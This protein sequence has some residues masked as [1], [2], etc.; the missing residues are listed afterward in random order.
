MTNL[1]AALPANAVTAAAVLANRLAAVKGLAPVKVRYNAAARLFYVT[2]PSPAAGKPA[3]VSFSGNGVFFTLN[4][5]GGLIFSAAAPYA[6]IYSRVSVYAVFS[7]IAGL[8]GLNP[9]AVLGP[10]PT[11]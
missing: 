9:A 8:Y 7:R 2:L 1:T 10:A 6:G 4:A 3:T 11:Y 5:G